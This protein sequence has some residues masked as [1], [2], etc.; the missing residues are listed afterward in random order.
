MFQSV[1]DRDPAVGD[2]FAQ[3]NM[4]KRLAQPEELDGAV[5]YLMSDASSY[6]TGN[7]FKIDGGAGLP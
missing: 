5:A 3:G 2:F 6:V 7:N 1:I 4:Q